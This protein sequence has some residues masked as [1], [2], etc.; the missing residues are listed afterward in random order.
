MS[1]A[2]AYFHGTTLICEKKRISAIRYRGSDGLLSQA[3]RKWL[4]SRLN[5]GLHRFPLS[6]DQP[7]GKLVSSSHCHVCLFI[8]TLF[9][10][11]VNK[12]PAERPVF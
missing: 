9:A 1:G 2:K 7:A 3:A 4:F 8:M 11:F 5:K 12:K 10:G 6:L